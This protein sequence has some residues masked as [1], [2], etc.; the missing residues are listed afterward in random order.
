M[1]IKFDN[2]P[3][4][5]QSVE[6]LAA[7]KAVFTEIMDALEEAQAHPVC[8]RSASLAITRLEEAFMWVG[9]TI[10]DLQIA[11][12]HVEEKAQCTE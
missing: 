5:S 11:K 12:A 1:T 4:D 3:Y 10:R 7:F 2:I 9:K 8:G 6:N